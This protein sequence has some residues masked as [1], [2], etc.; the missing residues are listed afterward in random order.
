[1]HRKSPMSTASNLDNLPEYTE[2]QAQ[3]D[4]VSIQWQKEIEAKFAE[5]DKMNQAYQH[6]QSCY[7]KI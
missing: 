3:L 1:M 4:E 6:R 2:A 7:L 5:V